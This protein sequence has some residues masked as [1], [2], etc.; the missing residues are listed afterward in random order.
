MRS[1]MM[2]GSCLAYAW[3]L[4]ERALLP[5]SSSRSLYSLSPCRVSQILRVWV[6]P[7]LQICTCA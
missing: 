1:T 4:G 5:P 7:A 3:P 6:R 2:S